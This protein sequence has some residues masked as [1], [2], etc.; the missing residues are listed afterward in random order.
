[1]PYEVD[2]NIDV[3]ACV[4][5]LRR[6]EVLG[7]EMS[8][9]SSLSRDP[10]ECE[11]KQAE[12]ARSQEQLPPP[13][14]MLLR[15]KI[16]AARRLVAPLRRA[17]CTACCMSVPRGDHGAILAGRTPVLCQHCGVLL[18]A[19]EEERAAASSPKSR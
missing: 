4:E 10:D 15:S 18:Y 6:L 8:Q 17:K 14:L 16:S 11:A 7:Q 13:V 2:T 9:P 12:F 1:M 3:L 5:P 19:D